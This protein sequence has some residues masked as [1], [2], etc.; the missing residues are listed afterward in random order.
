MSRNGEGMVPRNSFGIE[1]G[2]LPRCRDFSDIRAAGST[3]G[4]ENSTA[5]FEHGV[6][7]T[8]ARPT[9]LGVPCVYTLGRRCN[10]RP[11]VVNNWYREQVQ[12]GAV[13]STRARAFS[14][15]PQ[16]LRI[17]RPKLDFEKCAA[18]QRVRVFESSRPTDSRPTWGEISSRVYQIEGKRGRKPSLAPKNQTRSLSR[19]RHVSIT[20]VTRS[21][22]LQL[23]FAC[24]EHDGTAA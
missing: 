11:N 16:Q 21:S 3:N 9:F 20:E 6:P 10:Y 24:F 15:A 18:L 7:G 19:S 2:A 22:R 12:H 17:E 4:A 1:T 8:S 14:R 23:A 13:K 5:L